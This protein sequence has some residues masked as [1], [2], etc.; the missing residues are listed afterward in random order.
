MHNIRDWCI[1]RQIWWGHQIP[2]WTCE[3]CGEITVAMED[4]TA[5]GKCGGAHLTRDTDVLDTWFSSALWPFSTMG[6][7]ENTKLLKTFYPTATLVTGFDI[8]FFWVARMMMMGLHF[9]DDVP[10]RDVYVHALVR[11]EHGKKM[12]KSKGNVIDPLNVIDAYGTDAFR[13]TLTA[14]AAQ[15]RDIKMS[16]KRVEGYRNFINKLWNA[17][18]FALMHLQERVALPEKERL[19]VPD[20][21]ILSRLKGLIRETGQALD[22]YRFNDA[23]AMLYQFVWHEFCDWYLEA[24]KPALYGNQGE[25]R[26]H[27]TLGVLWR[28]LHDTLILLHPVIP[29]VTEEIWEKFPGTEGSIMQATFPADAPAAETIAEDT[30]AEAAMQIITQVITGIRNI[31]GEMNIAPGLKLNATVQTNDGDVNAPLQAHQDLV[32]N[33]ARLESLVI[34][35][36]GEKP[37]AAATAVIDGATIF[38]SLEGIIDFGQEAARLQKEIGKI[39]TELSALNNKLGNEDFLNKAPEAVVNKVKHQQAAFSEKRQALE[40]HLTRIEALAS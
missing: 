31:R 29:F 30:Q 19:S 28:V 7:P 17:A 27:A 6:W 16:E 15:G 3:D 12:S 1:S 39:D 38:V 20:R 18:R 5:C 40:M 37:K 8:L 36:L 24:I 2:A 21:W 11:D 22:D 4:P 13:F 9:M 34:E 10:F 35:P 32:S 14:F 25:D 23:A 33:L 26:Q